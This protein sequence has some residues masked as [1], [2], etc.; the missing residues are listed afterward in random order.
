MNETLITQARQGD[1]EALLELF[2]RY[3]PI[4]HSVRAR[5]FLQDFDE[6]DWFQEG[7]ITFNHCLH[8]YKG[9]KETTLGGFFKRSFENAIV[10]LVR[11]NCASKRKSVEGLV[12]YNQMFFS[13]GVKECIDRRSYTDDPLEQVIVQETLEESET[14][15]S[16]LE[17]EAFC[18]FFYGE[19]TAPSSQKSEVLR[20]AYDRSKRKITQQL[21]LCKR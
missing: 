3:R 10:S 21:I 18:G 12:S 14:L 4:V 17:K 13:D 11:K 16:E 20:S 15:L 1:E 19:I 9:D 5:F 7:L 6:Q 2:R 8:E